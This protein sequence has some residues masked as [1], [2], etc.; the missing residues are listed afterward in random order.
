[1]MN[2]LQLELKEKEATKELKIEKHGVRHVMIQ[3]EKD[4]SQIFEVASTSIS[5]II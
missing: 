5:L 4:D 2:K 3:T 1:M